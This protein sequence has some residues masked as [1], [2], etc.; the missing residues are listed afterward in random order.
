MRYFVLF[1]GYFLFSCADDGVKETQLP[2][3]EDVAATTQAAVPSLEKLWV[4]EGFAE[5]EGVAAAPMGGYFISNVSGGATDHDGSGWISLLSEDGQILDQHW[6]TGLD[7]PK[8][9][10]VHNDILY[11]ADIN[12][13]RL[14]D[15]TTGAPS[16]VVKI[17][18]AKF[19]NDVAAWQGDILVSDSR[20]ATIYRLVAEGA[21]IWIEDEEMLG[22][23]NGL[24]GD[25]DRLL[26]STMTTGTLFEA[27]A[28]RSLRDLGTG[29]IDADGIGIVPGGGYLVSAWRGDIFFAS[30]KGEVSK[31][32]DTRTEEISQNDLS[33]Y[34]NLVIV[35]NWQPGTVTGWRIVR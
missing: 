2:Q 33:V 11:V 22:G 4:T 23:V 1:L 35:P 28:D 9:M 31:L 21:E 16:G 17:E 26:I 19:L 32:L 30:E 5:P 20:S 25:G 29:M 13:V 7:A 34:G 27:D 15:T 12:S 18:S 3:E 8:G 10:A 6:A 14:Y 24:L